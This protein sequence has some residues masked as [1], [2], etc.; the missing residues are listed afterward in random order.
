MNLSESYKSMG[1]WKILQQAEST[2][3]K[4]WIISEKAL[5]WES[6]QNIIALDAKDKNN[7]AEIGL[8]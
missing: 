8:Q 2:G 4:I 5:V 3:T 7:I 1:G 6:K